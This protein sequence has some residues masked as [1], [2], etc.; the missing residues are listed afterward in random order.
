VGHDWR[1]D[2]LAGLDPRIKISGPI[3]NLDEVFATARLSVAPLRFGAGIKGKVLESFGAGLPCV[4]TPIAAEGLSLPPALNALVGRDA[5]KLAE[6]VLR[7]HADEESNTAAGQ[8]AGAIARERYSQHAV[9]EALRAALAPA[10][11]QPAKFRA[12][13]S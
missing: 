9:V 13:A 4:M 7:L 12:A 5:A 8:A 1:A 2:R 11:D 10:A 6:H 3:A